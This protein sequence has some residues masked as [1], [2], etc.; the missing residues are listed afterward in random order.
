MT[1]D[2]PAHWFNN[3]TH[4]LGKA[5]SE[6]HYW[7]TSQFSLRVLSTG[8]CVR[9]RADRRRRPSRDIQTSRVDRRTKEEWSEEFL[10]YVRKTDRCWIW[11]GRITGDYGYFNFQGKT[12]TAHR[13]AYLLLKGGYIPDGYQVRRDC[14]NRL[15]VNPEHLYKVSPQGLGQFL[16]ESRVKRKSRPNWY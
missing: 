12:I 4:E 13:A 11:R 7:G 1:V 6:R 2:R 14:N 3:K 5:C 16:T 8:E 10:K 9:C 15:C